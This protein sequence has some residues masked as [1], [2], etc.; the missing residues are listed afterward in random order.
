MTLLQ[1]ALVSIPS[2]KF[3][4]HVGITDCRKL[5]GT[6]LGKSPIA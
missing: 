4:H 3:V 6:I 2:H 5:K 1:V